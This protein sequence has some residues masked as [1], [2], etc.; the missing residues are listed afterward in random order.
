MVA[1]A[2]IR[3]QRQRSV[4][5]R[6]RCVQPC[7]DRRRRVI[8]CRAHAHNPTAT[9]LAVSAEHIIRAIR[10]H[11]ACLGRTF[12]HGGGISVRLRHIVHDADG[13]GI[14]G[15][16]AIR[17]GGLKGEAV[18]DRITR[19][20]VRQRI[21]I[22]AACRVNR[23]RAV[24][25]D[26][27]R[28]CCIGV[29]ARTT[30]G[31]QR[32]D[33]HFCIA[34]RVA[35]NAQC[36]FIHT[37]VRL[38]ANRCRQTAVGK[39]DRQR[40]GREVAVTVLDGVDKA[41]GSV[42]WRHRVGVGM[43]AVA[44]IRRQR[45][46]SV[47]SRYRC[48]Q[49]CADRRRRVASCCAHS[50]H[51]MTRSNCT[52]RTEHISRAIRQHVAC[53][54]RTFNHGGGISVRLRHIIH[55]RDGQGVGYGVPLRILNRVAE[56]VAART[57]CAVTGRTRQRVAVGAI[58][59]H[60][61]AA[62]RGRAALCGLNRPTRLQDEITTGSLTSTGRIRSTGQAGFIHS[63]T[64]HHR[65][66][67]KVVV[68]NRRTHAAGRTTDLQR[69][70]VATARAGNLHTEAFIAFD[71]GVVDGANIETDTRRASRYGDGGNAGVVAAVSGRARV[72]QV[73]HNSGLA[74]CAQAHGVRRARTFSHTG[75]AGNADGHHIDGVND[76]GSRTGAAQ[77]D[78]LEVATAG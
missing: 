44:A 36:S 13:Q 31:C 10:Q 1:V 78:L 59:A 45:Q 51:A 35:A 18:S 65:I 66:G 16:V 55:D 48:V 5:S 2:A 67:D 40:R 23:Q 43:V 68:H 76:A 12:N 50:H 70:K 47:R 54:G 6:Y 49:P 69:F 62:M 14:G 26:V 64:R 29:T 17:I 38:T 11:V 39:V 75:A 61:P 77:V 58:C 37:G 52:V 56:A 72:A 33:R 4:R 46:R 42:S 71:Q 41:V 22:G 27:I 34:G 30:T 32:A 73:D 9:I 21:G 63:A 24:V 15:L 28:H 7:A 53:R 57:W 60:T 3:R 20:L 8:A 74:R 25:G 19:G